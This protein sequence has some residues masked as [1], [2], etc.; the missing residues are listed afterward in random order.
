MN[1]EPQQTA[2]NNPNTQNPP[3]QLPQ[4]GSDLPLIALIGLLSL[5]TAGS[6]RFAAAKMK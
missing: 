5:G 3:A 4:T 1:T 6:L 2:Q